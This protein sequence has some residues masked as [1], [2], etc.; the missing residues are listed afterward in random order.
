MKVTGHHQAQRG[1]PGSALGLRELPGGDGASEEEEEA[2]REDRSFRGSSL[3][4]QCS[5]S[6]FQIPPGMQ[7]TFLSPPLPCHLGLRGGLGPTGVWEVERIRE[8]AVPTCF[9][10]GT[11]L[12][13]SGFSRPVE[14]TSPPLTTLRMRDALDVGEGEE[15]ELPLR[16]PALSNTP[17]EDQ[18]PQGKAHATRHLPNT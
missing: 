10:A 9:P 2:G 4:T 16:P 14:L 7:I 12:M 11:G 5:D 17:K 1:M 13:G 6:G 18:Q 8:P 15:K 3:R